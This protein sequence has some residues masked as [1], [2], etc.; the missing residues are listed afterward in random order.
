M[1]PTTLH[2]DAARAY[3]VLAPV[4]DL[5]TADY[6][7]G[8]WLSA[9]ERLAQRHGLAGRRLLDVG[10]GTGK[11]F[12]PMLER[13]FEVTACDISPEMVAEARRKAGSRAELHVADMR[14]LPVL[15]EF[16]LITCLDDAMNHLLGPEEL[17]AAF[18]GLAANLAAG[19][20]LV[21]DVN[22]LAAYRSVPDVVYGDDERVVCWRGGL[23]QLAEPGEQA[24]V[25]IDLFTHEGD[26]VWRRSLSRQRHRHHPV[27]E[28]RRIAAGAGLAVAAVLGQ[29]P[30]AVLDEELD[31]QVHGKAVFVMR[32]GG[33]SR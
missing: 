26:G 21:F 7:H 22:T 13:G 12:L 20:L 29:R 28:I 27:E 17:A 3:A 33:G 19:G 11:S 15:G 31:E 5:L 16:D 9:L 18:E 4:Y 8:P 25:V 14:R 32:S 2:S 1:T 6:A 24:E 10:C 30:G 23:A